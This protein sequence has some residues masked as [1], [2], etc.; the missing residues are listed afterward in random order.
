[1]KYNG[2]YLTNVTLH[3]YGYIIKL[4][5]VEKKK[6]HAVDNACYYYSHKLML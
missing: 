1:M 2:D 6:K 3:C 4:V 5:H